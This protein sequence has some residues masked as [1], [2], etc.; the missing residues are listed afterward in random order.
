MLMNRLL[1]FAL[2]LLPGLAHANP[3]SGP[4]QG[5]LC[6][7]QHPLVGLDHLLAMVAVGLW[8]AQLG[9]RA[10]WAVPAS[11]VGVMT[12][13]GLLGMAAW[14]LPL[15]ETGILLSVLLL[16]ILITFSVRVSAW[17]GAALVGVFALFH[18]HAHGTEVPVNV[19]G[20]LY[21]GGFL[22][23]TAV[24]H[25]AGIGCGLAMKNFRFAPALRVAGGCVLLGGVLLALG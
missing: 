9:G 16:G 24:L 1:P 15:V 6:G 20:W 3:A 11:F 14:T 18:G 8:A 23:A 10:V 22:A 21:V 2:L 7:F 5:F 19:S 12:L 17:M 25:A 4:A 13:G